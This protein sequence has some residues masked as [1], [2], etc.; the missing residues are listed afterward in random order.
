MGNAFAVPSSR[1]MP[2]N[3]SLTLSDVR[4]PTISLVCSAC[5]LR[6]THPVAKLIERYGDEALPEVLPRIAHCPLLSNCKAMFEKL[7]V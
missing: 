3:G 4:K 1:S 6:E 7:V 5:N 2:R